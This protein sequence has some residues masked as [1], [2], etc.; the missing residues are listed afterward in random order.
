MAYRPPVF[1]G[2]FYAA[3]PKALAASVSAWLQ[4]G[5]LAAAEVGH[6]PAAAAMVLLPHAGHIY[7]GRVISE[8]LARVRPVECMVILCPNH[9]GQGAPLAVWNKGAWDTPLGQVQVDEELAQAL[10]EQDAGYE[11]DERAHVREH[12]VEV[13]LPFMQC[14]SPAARIVPVAISGRPEHL[15]RAGNGLAVALRQ[16]G[17]AGR[18]AMVV[19]SSDMHHFSGEADTLRLDDRA[20]APLLALDPAGLYN[21][22]A[23]EHISMCGV[24]PATLALFAGKKLGI[25]RAELVAHTTSGEASG[26]RR[27]VV[28]YAGVIMN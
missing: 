11:A 9:N 26:D 17:E 23:R 7:C 19:V 6:E 3:D 20:L 28:G 22:V 13:L 14:H 2:S 16:A 18:P 15:M 5:A 12:S 4:S 1:A 10:L 8:T 24:Q 27:R 21:T 25:T